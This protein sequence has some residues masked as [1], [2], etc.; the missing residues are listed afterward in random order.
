MMDP[1]SIFQ[2]DVYVKYNPDNGLYPT[3]YYNERGSWNNMD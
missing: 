3:Y 2:N 1:D